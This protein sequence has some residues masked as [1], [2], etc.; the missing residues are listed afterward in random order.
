MNFFR[1]ITI[2]SL[3][4]SA[5]SIAYQSN[6]VDISLSATNEAQETEK[7]PDFFSFDGIQNNLAKTFKYLTYETRSN[8]LVSNEKQII[9]IKPKTVESRT[10][11]GHYLLGEYP[12]TDSIHP[13]AIIGITQTEF[14]YKK[15]KTSIDFISSLSSL[16]YGIGTSIDLATNFAASFEYLNH[17]NS[18]ATN[19]SFHNEDSFSIFFTKRF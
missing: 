12:I 10:L 6:S 2:I 9:E 19:N 7:K 4:F 18:E 17:N 13:Y 15:T 5:Q 16:S 14:G 8:T 11:Y 3:L 1:I